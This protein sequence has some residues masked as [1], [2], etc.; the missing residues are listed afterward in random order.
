MYKILLLFFIILFSFYNKKI[1][2]GF[3]F[4]GCP[5][6]EK[7]ATC[8]TQTCDNIIGLKIDDDIT[9]NIKNKR[10]NEE[11]E[12]ALKIIS[13]DFSIHRTDDEIRSSLQDYL[14]R[15]KQSES[16]IDNID[17][18][19]NDEFFNYIISIKNKLKE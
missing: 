19:N 14:M 18:F 3:W 2:E 12:K 7:C 17:D 15:M 13:K 5:E 16:S 9:D 4:F 8:E 1:V 10:I 6:C 11:I